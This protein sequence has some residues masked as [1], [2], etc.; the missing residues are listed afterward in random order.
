MSLINRP[1]TQKNL[2]LNKKLLRKFNKYFKY[3]NSHSKNIF[4]IL[5]NLQY[6]TNVASIF[7]IADALGVSDVFLAGGTPRPPFGKQ[8]VKVSRHKEK[9]IKW[10][11]FKTTGKAIDYLTR[12]DIPVIAVEQVSHALPFYAIH[13]P[14]SFALLVGN[15]E[16][17]I[18]KVVLKKVKNYVFIP[19]FG[20]GASLNVH[21]SLAIVGF[22]AIIPT[23][24]H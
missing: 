15:E 19:M 23:P 21:V 6:A 4:I 11:Y 5:D 10:R 20:K 16:H 8:L 7:R 2:Y 3:N 1:L 9:H 24:G 17:G 13:Y 18:S 14:Q 12:K 22:Y